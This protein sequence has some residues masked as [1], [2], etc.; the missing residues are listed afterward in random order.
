MSV[1]G[2]QHKKGFGGALAHTV[3]CALVNYRGH[4]RHFVKAFMV[5]REFWEVAQKPVK[6][7][8]GLFVLRNEREVSRGQQFLAE[9][10][11]ESREGRGGRLV[12]TQQES[13]RQ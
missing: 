1:L 3:A 12:Q 4:T 10:D 5:Q 7:Y 11:R 9:V 13:G 2:Q 8:F 6:C